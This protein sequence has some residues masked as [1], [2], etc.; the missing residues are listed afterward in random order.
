MSIQNEEYKAA[1]EERRREFKTFESDFKVIPNPNCFPVQWLLLKLLQ[2]CICDSAIRTKFE[3][4]TQKG[5][6]IMS[7]I[8]EFLESCLESVKKMRSE[9]GERHSNQ[10]KLYKRMKS[11]CKKW[12]AFHK[13]ELAKFSNQ[14]QAKVSNISIRVHSS[15]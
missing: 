12:E 7:A 3:K 8:T 6:E 1:I 10:V 14:V 2:Y 13:E 15:L 5:L 4:H 9:L 11:G